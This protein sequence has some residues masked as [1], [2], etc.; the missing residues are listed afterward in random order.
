MRNRTLAIFVFAALAVSVCLG[1]VTGVFSSVKIGTH[2]VIPATTPGYTGTAGTGYLVLSDSPALIGIPTAPTATPGTNTTQLAT[3]AFVQAAAGG[4]SRTCN[5]NGCYRTAADGTIEAWGA[6]TAVGSPAG[7]ANLT[8]TFPTTFT[9]TTNLEVTVSAISDATG[10]GNP[11]PANCHITKTSLSTS[12]AT[13]VISVS[14]QIG[15]SGYSNLAAGDYCS[16]HAF[17]N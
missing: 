13:A 9:T 4:G 10:D 15:G 8:I 6:S 11:H 5:A 1:A 2:T 12:G 3:T 7:A 14:T 17:G 16:F